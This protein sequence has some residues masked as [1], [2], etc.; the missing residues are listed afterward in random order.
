MLNK[1]VSIPVLFLVSL[2]LS[3]S[4][5][6]VQAQETTVRLAWWGNEPRHDMYG[7][8]SDMYEEVTD[9][10]L[11]REFNA[12][13]PYWELLATQVAGGNLPDILHMHP[14]FVNE[15]A[16]RGTLLDLTPYVES[17]QLDLSTFPAGIV[18]SG[19]VG[20]QIF[21]VT[22][23]NSS[24]GTHYNTAYF[25]EAAIEFDELTWT[26]DDYL[27]IARQL[28]AVMPEDSWAAADDGASDQALETFMRQR[29]K[30]F[31]DADGIA[32]DKEDL[33]DFWGMFQT[34]REEGLIPPADIA[35]EFANVGHADS[36]LGN[37]R[38]AM[39][40]LSGNQHKLFQAVIDDELGLAVIPRTLNEDGDI[41]HGD[42]IGGAYLACSADTEH[43]DACIDYINWMVNDPD[44][45][46]IYNGEHGPPGNADLAATLAA[47]LVPADQRMFAM[48]AYIA[49]YASNRSQR[50]DWG[51]E[52]QDAYTRFY[53]ELAFGNMSLEQAVDGFFEEIDFISS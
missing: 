50:P 39:D 9:V 30:D 37:G 8:L 25:E 29:G 45:S 22:L 42:V 36:L 14:N 49:P 2:L 15:Y 41:Q 12:W 24:P 6:I 32:F 23:G 10:T 53:N 1:K 48:M 13:G 34:M 28:A 19:K 40:I 16:S 5:G 21:M 17:G 31:M 33:L 52:A 18:D 44:V 4:F 51:T 26:W 27:E 38:V 46:E 7:M 35:Q 47:D 20:E 11:E 43:A 3:V